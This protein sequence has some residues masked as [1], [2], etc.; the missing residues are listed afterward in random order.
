MVRV[1][2]HKGITPKP[3]PTPKVVPKLR[4][5]KPR[6]DPQAESARLAR[7]QAI[8]SEEAN[9]PT[10][11]PR[12]CQVQRPPPPRPTRP[13]ESAR[14]Q[15]EFARPTITDPTNQGERHRHIRQPTWKVPLAEPAHTIKKPHPPSPDRRNYP[16]P[17]PT[18]RKEGPT[19]EAAD[20]A[21]REEKRKERETRGVKLPTPPAGQRYF[22]T[23]PPSVLVVERSALTSTER[24]LR[25]APLSAEI[26]RLRTEHQ[27]Y[28]NRTVH[29]FEDE[30]LRLT[31][32][33]ERENATGTIDCIRRERRTI[34][35]ETERYRA[36]AARA[37]D[38]S[39]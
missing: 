2:Q 23:S 19:W 5:P 7:L 9:N 25:R 14:P 34:R 31:Q 11:M 10:L 8:E 20:A 16:R 21:G 1:T 24:M 30:N 3:T 28:L 17:M 18:G 22:T 15:A 29:R 35:A 39:N 33:L 38:P 12:A 6:F 13:A 27:A 36:L 32:L 4:I 37:T 26:E